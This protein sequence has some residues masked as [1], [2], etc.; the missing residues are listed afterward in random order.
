MWLR[1]GEGER[2]RQHLKEKIRIR[3][4]EIGRYSVQPTKIKAEIIPHM[5]Y[6]FPKG[7]NGRLHVVARI[8]RPR[9]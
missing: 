9:P 6:I 3:W 5:G 2:R 1:F 8:P 7:R 4:K